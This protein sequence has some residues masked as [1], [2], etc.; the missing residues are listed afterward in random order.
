[1]H[2]LFFLLAGLWAA[3]LI[4][5][6]PSPEFDVVEGHLEIVWGDPLAGSGAPAL[7]QFSLAGDDGSRIPL[8]VSRELAA[9][10]GGFLD[11]FGQRVRVHLDPEPV[12]TARDARRGVR[13]ARALTLL[14]GRD[15]ARGGITGSQPWVSILCRFSDIAAEPNDLAYFE[16]MYGTNFGEL[17][18]YW[19]K[20]SYGA[21]DIV[22]S[23]A[24]DWVTLPRPQSFYA[25]TPGSGFDADKGALF[26]DC[27]EAADPFVD[28]SNGGTGGF[29]GINQMFNDVLDCCAWG[30]GRFASLDG[31]SKVWRVTWN[32]PWAQNAAVIAH[33]MGHG[34]GLPHANNFD[35]DGDPYDSPWDVMSSAFL[36][37]VDTGPYGIQ[38][39]H[40]TA[41]HKSRLGWLA[42]GEV[43]VVNEGD[44]V[45]AIVDHMALPSTTN[46]RAV[47]IPIPGT[48]DWYTVEVRDRVG[49]D[50]QLPGNA[51]IIS[52]VDTGRPEPAWAIDTDD[53]PANFGSNEGTMFR[54]GEVFE[55]PAVGIRVA[56]I[57]AT[58]EGFELDIESILSD[59]VFLDGFEIAGP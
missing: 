32:P 29:A 10:H 25:P 58:A 37:A 26:D 19:R 43:L 6:E 49:Y 16:G 17:D 3:P 34:F 33:E 55:D 1:M 14:E 31:V 41:Y 50:G 40:H 7:K 53:P 5:S 48:D 52:Q 8:T 4:A 22:G 38:G 46:L 39:K 15:A 57:A 51:V 30:G 54:V 59:D 9:A 13:R 21:I 28:F 20:Q 23:I 2:R 56:V 12:E 47:E 35:G 11:W 18:D 36:N 42:P 45:T 44:A 27:S 24:V